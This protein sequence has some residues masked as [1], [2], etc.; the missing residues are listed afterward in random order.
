MCNQRD[1]VSVGRHVVWDPTRGYSSKFYTGM[2][3]FKDITKPLNPVSVISQKKKN[4]LIYTTNAA[5]QTYCFYCFPRYF[6]LL[7]LIVLQQLCLLHQVGAGKWLRSRV[8]FKEANK[9]A[10][11][12]VAC[13]AGIFWA[14]ECTFSY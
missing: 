9:R 4:N 3:W 14:R 5:S 1:F 7:F 12:Y 10:L 2:L 8:N 13:T 6:V 11:I